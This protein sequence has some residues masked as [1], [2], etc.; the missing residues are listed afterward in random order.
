MMRRLRSPHT[1]RVAL[2]CALLAAPAVLSACSENP[3]F[4]KTELRNE[5]Q[6]ASYREPGTSTIEGRVALR[7]PSGEEVYG[8]SCHVRAMPVSTESDQYMQSIVLPG[9]V[10]SPRQELDDV[11]W[12]TNADGLGRFRFIDMPAGSYWVTCAMA[13]VQDGKTREGIAFARAVVG[14]GERVEVQVTRGT[15]QP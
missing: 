9:A 7:L 15:G 5:T 4:T 11:S 6:Y 2:T 8:S 13:W 14:A 12:L 10:S 3:V 1:S